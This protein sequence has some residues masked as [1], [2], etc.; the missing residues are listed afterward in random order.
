[1]IFVAGFLAMG[2]KMLLRLALVAV[3]LILASYLHDFYDL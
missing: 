2:V 3:M 1:M